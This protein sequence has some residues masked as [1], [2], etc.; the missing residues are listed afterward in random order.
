MG[1]SRERNHAS[2]FITSGRICLR[3]GD[4]IRSNNPLLRI[5]EP[6]NP[7]MTSFINLGLS[8]TKGETPFAAEDIKKLNEFVHQHIQKSDKWYFDIPESPVELSR[9][10]SE[11]KGMCKEMAAALIVLLDEV[12]MEAYLVSGKSKVQKSTNPEVAH[13]W[14]EIEFQGKTYLAD[15][16]YEVFGEKREAVQQFGY[17]QYKTTIFRPT[18]SRV[19]DWLLTAMDVLA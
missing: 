16:M 6:G 4:V 18:G 11:R 12:G 13:A 15:P 7:V 3:E 2:G 14:V 1:K 9:S 17:S 10:V 5:T 19:R 8:Q